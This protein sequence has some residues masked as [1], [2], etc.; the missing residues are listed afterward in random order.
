MQLWKQGIIG[1]F[2]L[3]EGDAV[4]QDNAT[5]NLFLTL[6]PQIDAALLTLEES[7]FAPL[8]RSVRQP[9]G[10]RER[11][12]VKDVEL[13]SK[14]SNAS[15]S[16]AK[17]IRLKGTPKIADDIRDDALALRA[18]TTPRSVAD[19]IAAV[20]TLV[21]RLGSSVSASPVRITPP[22]KKGVGIVA[23]SLIGVLAALAGIMA[24]RG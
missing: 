22:K 11:I 3:Q 23:I 13:I 14:I 5:D 21:S 19:N 12:T 9:Q 18:F 17:E 8:G 24:K 10:V 20:R 4:S 16:I 2:Q 1:A 15:V 7:G 6:K